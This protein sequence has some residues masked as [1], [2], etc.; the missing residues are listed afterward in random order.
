M[1]QNATERRKTSYRQETGGYVPRQFNPVTRERFLRDRR[2]KYL[3]RVS[4]PATDA[5]IA[6]V[7]SLARLE[8][9]ALSAE[10]EN[11]L[12]SL[13]EGREHRR[14]LL[15][16][17][18]DFERSLAAKS[19]EKPQRTLKQYLSLRDGTTSPGEAA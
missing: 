7:Q 14:L 16:V 15:R 3:S 2:Q 4:D 12:H 5:Q 8:W 11:T 19:T 18:A 9:A 10:Q 1:K 13:R 6:M 17:L